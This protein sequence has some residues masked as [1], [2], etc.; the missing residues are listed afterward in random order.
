VD[1]DVAR[2]RVQVYREMQ[3]EEPDEERVVAAVDHVQA[4]AHVLQALGGGHADWIRVEQQ[5]GCRSVVCFVDSTYDG[6]SL[7]Y[8]AS[9]HEGV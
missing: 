7:V 4:A 2:F 3:R 9:F 5:G 8:E 1:R 6:T